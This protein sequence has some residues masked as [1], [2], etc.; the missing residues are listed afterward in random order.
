LFELTLRFGAWFMG[1]K[2]RPFFA[3]CDITL[4]RTG[5]DINIV[6]PDLMIICDLEENLSEKGYYIGIP[7][8]VV[9]ILSK[10]TR[11]KDSVEKLDL[12]KS[13]GVSEYWI[14][15]PMNREIKVYLFDNKNLC[16]LST[17]KNREIAESFVFPGLKVALNAIF[18]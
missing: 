6:Q 5:E 7:K 14:V 1:K 13:T 8:L 17:Y 4:K 12:Y 16:K 2:C 3:P 15:D 9:E 11:S 10:S 18:K